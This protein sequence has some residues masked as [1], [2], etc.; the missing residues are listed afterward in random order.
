[1]KIIPNLWFDH[2]AEE[3]AHFYVL[4]FKQSRVDQVT[5]AFLQ[6][7]KFKIRALEAAFKD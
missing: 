7:K 1:M 5:A 6:M 4:T 2:Q 3:A